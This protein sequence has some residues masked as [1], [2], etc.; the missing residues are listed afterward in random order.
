MQ[1]NQ[2]QPQNNQ[3]RPKRRRLTLAEVYPLRWARSSNNRPRRKSLQEIAAEEAE[4]ALAAAA[5]IADYEAT[6]KA[7]EETAAAEK[8]APTSADHRRPAPVPQAPKTTSKS[9]PKDNL[10]ASCLAPQ[11]KL[12]AL[13][14]KPKDK[15]KPLP[16]KAALAIATAQKACPKTKSQ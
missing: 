14:P 11:I 5:A 1:Q 6:L 12:L 2:V 15:S 3:A 13:P 9:V 7:A 8:A 16:K 10:K 4:D